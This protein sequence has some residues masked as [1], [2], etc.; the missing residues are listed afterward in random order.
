MQCKVGPCVL[1]AQDMRGGRA[2][3][4]DVEQR[5]SVMERAAFTRGCEDEARQL[6]ATVWHNSPMMNRPSLKGDTMAAKKVVHI[7]GT[8]TIGEPLIGLFLN[9][10]EQL[11]LD[12]ITFHKN[13]PLLERSCQSEKSH[14]S[15]C[16]AR[17]GR[18]D[19]ERL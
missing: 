4:C 7:I 9:L 11:E 2:A 16:E 15:R 3:S 10:R 8:G 1:G 18:R 6:Y 17:R 12:E 19:N 13:R 5:L 14:S